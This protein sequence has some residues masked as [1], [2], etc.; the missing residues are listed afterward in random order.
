MTITKI[1]YIIDVFQ[2][3]LP[4]R[5]SDDSGERCDCETEGFQSTLPTRGSDVSLS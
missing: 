4:T 2:S 5:G 3:T 1:E